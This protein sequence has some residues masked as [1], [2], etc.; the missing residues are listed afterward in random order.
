MQTT[1]LSLAI[2][3]IL[4]LLAALLGP[5]FID[6][7][8]HRATFEQQASK[9]V[10]LPVRVTGPM[11]VR[12]LPSPRLVLS[13]VEIGK[14]DDRHAVRAKALAIEF[15]LPPL[16]SGKL[17][18]VEMRLIGPEVRLSLG[19]D[20]RA[21]VPNL[22]AG[23]STET[24]SI[25][26]LAIDDARV[27]LFDVA[28]GGQ[29]TLSKLWF[30]GEVRA[31]PGPIR[32]EGAFVLN[33]GLYSYRISA[34]RPEAN[35]SRIRLSI[36][37]ADRPVT[38]DVEGV[39]TTETGIPRFEG[40]A[41]LTRRLASGK[42]DKLNKR[43]LALVE[44]WRITSRVK[45]TAANALFEQ[46]E[47]LYGPEER[48]L[49]LT[50]TAE[51]KFGAKPR[52]DVVLSARQL[53]ADKL[54]AATGHAN[55]PPRTAIAAVLSVAG[56][57]APPPLPTQIGFGIDLV[58]LGGGTLQNVRGDIE[59]GGSAATLSGFEARGPGMTQVQASGQI[60]TDGDRLSF[61]GPVDV[62]SNDPRAFGEW[63]EGRAVVE[64]PSRPARMRGD[65][66][67]S[68]GKVALER[69]RAEFDRKTFDGDFFYVAATEPNQRSRFDLRLR[70]DEIDLDALMQ[71]AGSAKAIADL[72]R[73][74][75][76][77][78]SLALG[79]IRFAGIDAGKADVKL[80]LN[81]DGLT[82]ERL[83][84]GDLAGLSIDSTGRIDL[85]SQTP[86]GSLTFNLD[87]RD[88][89]VLASLAERAAPAWLGS[90]ERTAAVA[91][92]AKLAGTI[93]VEPSGK[94]SRANV[95]VGGTLGSTQVNLKSSLTGQWNE[96]GQAD[97]T[98]DASLD[99]ADVNALVTLAAADKWVSVPRQPGTYTVSL[100]GKRD[101]DMRLDTRIVSANLDAR[102]NGMI[103]PFAE[104]ARRAAL[105]IT[106]GK[107]DVL[108]DR[109]AVPV[110]LRT[111]V[112]T[113]ALGVKLDNLSGSIAGTGLRGRLGLAFSEVPMVDGELKADAVDVAALF[114]ALTGLDTA[115]KS[116]ND[117]WNETPFS[118]SALPPL[119]GELKM[120]AAK[121]VLSP[122][123]TASNV[124][125]TFRFSPNQVKA[126][127]LE[128]DLL[129]GRANA[130][131]TLRRGADGIGIQGQVV[132]KGTDASQ[133]LF[134]AAQGPLVGRATLNVQFEGAG[135]SPR[136][137]IGSLNGGGMLTLEKAR[138]A[139]LD[140]S[141]FSVAMRSVDQ[142]LPLDAPRIR[143]VVGRALDAGSLSIDSA[144][145]SLAIAGGIARIET[146]TANSQA[147]D[148]AVTGSYNL[149]DARID[150]RLALTGAPVAGAALRPE[151]LVLLR[152]PV[153]A[154]E[155][156]LDVSALIGWLALRS[157]DQQAKRIEALEQGRPA[158]AAV[159]PDDEETSALPEN[160]PVLPPR[161][162]TPQ[163][164]ASQPGSQPALEPLPPP[165]EIK[166]TA[167][168]R[169]RVPHRVESAPRASSV[170][171]ATGNPF[172]Q[173]IGHPPPPQPQPLFR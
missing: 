39:L 120:E 72:D 119:G 58:T 82:V 47:F 29:T 41:T 76:V 45:A 81:A 127:P 161:R 162:P 11:D 113:D 172:P 149:A 27:E 99:A 168:D 79:R 8:T 154:P 89:T 71:F 20:G 1:L 55:L 141:A 67:L 153:A 80:A 66:T 38:A 64:V 148:L 51:A 110:M 117:K 3:L 173:P 24:L 56:D 109:K 130:D 160:T 90:L 114:A 57:M 115:K 84:V 14:P 60:H 35:G 103:R 52:L 129:G 46:V 170:P 25:D 133:L 28:S 23:V 37:P 111:S 69:M 86:R 166:P 142:G 61:V 88:P 169:R 105:D 139:A 59:I 128:G 144:D 91:A 100:Q 50:G 126:A 68:A 49:K 121:A 138:L 43:D 163:P 13:G 18:A 85:K 87:M 83:A 136:A 53:D 155:R 151:L 171:P 101:G 135:L 146:F 125:T 158:E 26:K 42:G 94:A 22:L 112:K 147:A 165:V 6:W 156:T 10:G 73:P 116:P 108:L 33:G 4:V 118:P 32:G 95:T 77:A 145:A 106:V 152:G 92:P 74:D 107:A 150:T 157:V 75:D 30:D 31:L 5:H 44:P 137:L 167:G 2:A 12:L 104:D 48:A 7:N 97:I 102:A 9:A 40:Q 16:F 34:A 17:R 96:I 123:L 78:L 54:L 140:P 159:K 134:A 19:A 62:T 122:S 93:T 132:V 36:D 15:A 63:L 98:L 21:A 164:Q 131:V 124:R 70:A 65:L 143:D